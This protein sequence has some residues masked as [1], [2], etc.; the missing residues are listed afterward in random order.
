M[1]KYLYSLLLFISCNVCRYE[2]VYGQIVIN[3]NFYPAAAS[4]V[5]ASAFGV[6]SATLTAGKLYLFIAVTT[7][8]TNNGTVTATSTTWT[9]VANVGNSTRRVQVFRCMPSV[10]VSGE[11]VQ[12]G[13]F[14]GGSSGS[15]SAIW[16]ITG[17]PTTGI[18]GADAIV[19]AVTATGTASAN[20][21]LTLAPI[22]N[23]HN[24][25]IAVFGNSLNPF[26]GVPESGWTEDFD[27]GYDTPTAGSYIMS[28]LTTTDNTPSVTAASSDWA[29]IAIE[30]KA[31]AT[32]RII[33]V[34]K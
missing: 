5:D 9:N 13:S 10:T 31:T 22:S 15:A 21:S 16:E 24:V 8:T 3:K 30:L 14:G 1:K 7:G 32:R 19:Q 17:V 4:T 18:N 26:G 23:S 25:V 28:R 29:G 11:S 34:T 20:P 27:S 33:S 12:I 6:N 2:T